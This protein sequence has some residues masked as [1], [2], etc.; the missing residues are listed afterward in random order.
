MVDSLKL[1]IPTDIDFFF[2]TVQDAIDAGQVECV[3]LAI[4]RVD[5]DRRA[6]Y[7]GCAALDCSEC[8]YNTSWNRADVP[9]LIHSYQNDKRLG[10]R[11]D[12]FHI[13]RKLVHIVIG[14]VK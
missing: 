8:M 1:P 9:E 11:S 7:M 14:V 6:E 2:A 5:I 3:G 13:N 4:S 12:N 10:D